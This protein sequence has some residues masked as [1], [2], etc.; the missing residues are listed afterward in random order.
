MAL[1][2]RIEVYVQSMRRKP[3]SSGCTAASFW[4]TGGYAAQQK[5]CTQQGA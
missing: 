4:R 5:H 1:S 3:S 2:N